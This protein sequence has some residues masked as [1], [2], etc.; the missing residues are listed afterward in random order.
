ML[1]PGSAPT[2]AGHDGLNALHRRHVTMEERPAHIADRYDRLALISHRR[3]LRALGS[4]GG[5]NTLIVSSDWQI[6]QEVI[7]EGRHCVFFEEGLLRWTQLS[8]ETFE[9]IYDS[10]WC[11]IDGADATRFKNVSL[12]RQFASETG[13]FMASYLKLDFALRELVKRYRPKSIALY[14]YRLDSN[15]VPAT[16]RRELVRSIARDLD[17]AYDDRFDDPG[18]YDDDLPSEPVY[19]KTNDRRTGMRDRL[20]HTY[21]T[22]VDMVSRLAIAV[23]PRRQRI[24]MATG[25]HVNLRLMA[26]YARRAVQP[27]YFAR[28]MPKKPR[29]VLR[30]LL[31]G[32]GLIGTPRGRLPARDRRAVEG[33][34]RRFADAWSEP[35]SGI[36]AALRAYVREQFFESGA[37]AEMAEAVWQSERV[38]DRFRPDR[39]IVDSVKGWPPRMQIEQAYNRNI[40]VD[41]IWH[42]PWSVQ[43]LRFEP[44]GCDSRFPSLVTRCLSWGAANDAWLDRIGARTARRRVGSPMLLRPTKG[45]AMN[46]RRRIRRVLA[47][48]YTPIETDVRGLAAREYEFFVGVVPALQS[49]GYDVRV[50]L[51]PGSTRIG[52]YER[53]ATFFGFD[54]DILKDQPFLEC[55]GWADAVVGPVMSGA[56]LEVLAAGKPYYPML[57]TPHGFDL[58]D[59]AGLTTYETVQELQTALD[60]TPPGSAAILEHFCSAATIEDPVDA[61]WR[62]LEETADDTAVTRVLSRAAS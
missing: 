26:G 22:A 54:V 11:L 30:T 31:S 4:C 3:H 8:D 35:A 1:H 48:Q 42:A 38:I 57:M 25:L 51:H 45:D 6:W 13:V 20:I 21:E 60:E 36:T 14:D 61:V 2:D 19:L 46:P 58:S 27:I 23:V 59:Y 32:A 15:I 29:F 53:I 41:Y 12:G 56:L 47:L 55:V 62:A 16:A 34:L 44:L 9:R 17:I 50:K 24:L 39:V 7:A 28:P 5:D 49:A 10:D 18:W 33:I 40:P 37:F 52:Y 43:N